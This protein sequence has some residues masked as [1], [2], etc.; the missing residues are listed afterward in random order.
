MCM[1]VVFV[2]VCSVCVVCLLAVC[3]RCVCVCLCARK[4]LSIA[5]QNI[6]LVLK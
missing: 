4:C 5:R 3:V 2:C 6:L 1:C